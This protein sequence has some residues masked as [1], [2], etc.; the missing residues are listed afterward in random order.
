MPAS[1]A[2][3]SAGPLVAIARS[4]LIAAP[5]AA[6]IG[7]A[8]AL[9]LWLLDVATRTREAHPWLLFALPLAGV[10][11]VVVYRALGGHAARGTDLILDEIHEPGD[12][13]VPA[14]MAPLVLGATIVT[15][16]FG[17]SAGREGTAVQIGGS[18]AAAAGRW[19]RLPREE[20]RTLLRVGIAAG[21]GGVFGT[22]VAGAIFAI[23][24]LVAGR[25]HLAA[26]VP[27]V[28]AGYVGDWGCRVWGVHHTA[29]EVSAGSGRF[30]LAPIAAIALAAI[31]FGLASRLFADLAH[32]LK[33]AWRRLI[34]RE[35]LR[36][37]A[38]AAVVIALTFALGTRDYLGLGVT[39]PGGISIV[40]SFVPG[41]SITAWSWAW[42]LLFTAVTLSSGFKGG[43]VTPLFFIGATL[44]HALA[45]PLGVPVD[46]L[47]A[48]GF[49]AVFAGATKTPIAC[50]VMAVE[51]FGG[52]HVVPF[53]IACI[54]AF[55]V[56][57]RS[58]IYTSRRTSVRTR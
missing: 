42:K 31:A 20:V 33:D 23:E 34:A 28:V 50:T 53:A 7:S 2:R 57:G 4:A 14:R 25:P 8:C 40:D 24:V 3:L 48:C 22:P 58:G 54:V 36:P 21:F 35:W 51:L 44:G 29:Y 17:G 27:C 5:V 19:L 46:A 38:G 6:I 18:V 11:I 30:D 32:G 9:F 1:N 56:S 10:G 49:V 39:S 52:A 12:L 47:A 15:H 45:I 16:L 41:G 26:I 55:A 43:E 13:G 37:V